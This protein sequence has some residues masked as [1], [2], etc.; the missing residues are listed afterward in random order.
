MLAGYYLG[1]VLEDWQ[2]E[3]GGLA[4]AGLGDAEHVF[5]GEELGNCLH[6]DRRRGF[7]LEGS[8]ATKQRLGDAERNKRGIGQVKS[9][10]ACQP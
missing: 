4:G 9:F 7:V 8:E 5:A 6:L 2:A 3:R 1:K 10:C